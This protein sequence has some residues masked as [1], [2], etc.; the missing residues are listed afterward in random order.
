MYAG[1]ALYYKAHEVAEIYALHPSI[2][3]TV[4]LTLSLTLMRI[5]L[6]SKVPHLLRVM[7]SFLL[8]TTMETAC[9]IF[10]MQL[11][12]LDLDGLLDSND[13]KISWYLILL[14]AVL[15][16]WNGDLFHL[17]YFFALFLAVRKDF[18]L[19]RRLGGKGQP[20]WLIVN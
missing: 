11:I 7:W 4:G 6:R 9:I 14:T 12:W 1:N 18:E 2:H 20:W 3:C 8:L 5:P 15:D 19:A 16:I 10:D 13:R 17:Q